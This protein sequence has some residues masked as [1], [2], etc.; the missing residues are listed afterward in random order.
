MLKLIG[1]VVTIPLD[2]CKIHKE[3]LEKKERQQEEQSK[4][5]TE[6]TTS[7]GVPTKRHEKKTL[8]S[9]KTNL[10]EQFLSF[11]SI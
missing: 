4:T 9:V 10:M 5:K 2:H 3:K 11:F 7:G 6:S 1:D 8:T